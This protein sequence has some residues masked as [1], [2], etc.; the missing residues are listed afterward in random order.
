MKADGG[1]IVVIFRGALREDASLSE[2]GGLSARMTEI[3]T[4]LPGFISKELVSSTEGSA[5]LIV[6]FEN[7]AALEVWRT[8]PEHVE[9]MQ[10]GRDDFYAS[11]T[12]Q[13]CRV[14]R[15]SSF[16]TN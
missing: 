5:A 1:E 15:E 14:I 13:V 16:P 2:Y 12:M 8:H 9:V 4:G 10:R 7:E 3:V 6:R 11:Y